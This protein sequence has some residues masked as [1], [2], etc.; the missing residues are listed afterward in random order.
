MNSVVIAPS[1]RSDGRQIGQVLDSGHIGEQAG[2]VAKIPLQVAQLGPG[3]LPGGGIEMPGD[4]TRMPLG[5][6]GAVFLIQLASS[7]AS[8]SSRVLGSLAAELAQP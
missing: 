6:E 7:V 5:D 8:L 1:L 4:P 2:I 3:T